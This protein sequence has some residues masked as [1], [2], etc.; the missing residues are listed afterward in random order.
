MDI[1]IIPMAA[2]LGVEAIKTALEPGTRYAHQMQAPLTDE[3]S[4]LFNQLRLGSPCVICGREGTHAVDVWMFKFLRKERSGELFWKKDTHYYVKVS[5]VAPLCSWHYRLAKVSEMM[6]CVFS[7]IGVI[8]AAALA[9]SMFLLKQKGHC[10]LPVGDV[11]TLIWW[12]IIGCVV[13]FGIM[14]FLLDKCVTFESVWK[15]GPLK[16]LVE[17]RWFKCEKEDSEFQ[18]NEARQKCGL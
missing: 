11:A 10:I 8:A 3:E 9:Y 5:A 2:R 17:L 16:R 18:L 14:G 7:L 12:F 13:F 1:R 4:R 15:Y 6:C